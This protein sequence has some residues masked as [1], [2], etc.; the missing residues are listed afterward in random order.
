[1]IWYKQKT[2]WAGLA[3]I[4]TGFGEIVCGED[5]AAAMSHM[6]QGVGLVFLRQAITSI[7][8]ISNTADSTKEKAK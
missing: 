6:L 5:K 7:T 8:N 1:M 2:T 3:L 4:I